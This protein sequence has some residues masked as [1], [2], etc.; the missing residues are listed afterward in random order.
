MS[1]TKKLLAGAMALTLG[2]SSFYLPTQLTEIIPTNNLISAS[3]ETS[4][5]YEYELLDDGTVEIT[6]YNGED[7]NVTIPSAIAGKKVTSIG[8]GAFYECTSLTSVTIPNSVTSI[9]NWV[10]SGCSSLKSITIPSSVT[11]IGEDSFGVCKSLKNITIDSN[12]NNYSSQDGVLFN[13]DKTRLIKYPG[14]NTRI[15]YN[16]P[17][18]VTVIRSS[19][20]SDCT[21]LKIITIPNSIKSIGDGAFSGCSSL[22]NV[23]IPNSVTSIGYGAFGYCSSL[24]SI[25]IPNSVT[26]IGDNAFLDCDFLEIINTDSNNGHYS[27]KDGVLFNKDKTKLIKYPGANTR[28]SYTIPNGVITISDY[29]FEDCD[30]LTSI[31]IP[32]SVID[33]NNDAFSSCDF[34]S[35][36]VDSDNKIYSSQNGILFNKNK[37]E[38]IKCLSRASEISIPNS[39][40]K[41]GNSAFESCYNLTDLFIYDNVKTIG[42]RAFSSCYNLTSVTI[43]NGVTNI[44]YSAFEYCSNLTDVSFGNSVTSIGS[45]VFF[46]CESLT[47][48]TIPKSVAYIGESAFGWCE[49]LKDIYYTGTEEDFNRIQISSNEDDLTGTNNDDLIN[50]TIHYNYKPVHTHSYTSK[51]T[52][53]PTCTSTGVRTYTCSC[54]D[55]YT[56]IIP[57]IEHDYTSAITKQPTCTEEGVKTY[58]CSCGDNYTETLPAT[59]HKYL[60]TVIKPTY[61]EQGYT[62]HKCSVCGSS[63]KDNYTA[64]LTLATVSNFKVTKTAYN[65]IKLGWNAVPNA[66]GYIIWR[67][68]FAKKQ[69]IKIN[70]NVK[71]NSFLFTHL[72]SGTKYRFSVRAFKKVNGKTVTSPS[73]PVVDGYTYLPTVSNFK[74]TATA[75]NAIKLGWNKVA[76]ANGYYIYRYDYAKKQWKLINNNVKS[77]TFLFTHLNSGSNYKFAVRAFKKID[78]K[79]IL[80]QSFPTVGSSTNPATVNFKVTA[81]SKK[82]TVKW[83]KVTGATGYKVYYKTSKNGSWKLIK[84]ANNKTTSYTKTGL[85]KGKTY[86]FTVK[87]YRTVGGKTYNGKFTT[88]SVKIK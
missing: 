83:S 56:E 60:T 86:Y 7:E 51:I 45:Y 55:S 53:Q 73:F 4:G 59:G 71:T 34:L 61:I 29:A 23:T 63:Y 20:F 79:N 46:A 74:V 13:K 43:G 66:D 44:G 41:I 31:I 25:T 15:S 80:S 64:K 68:D 12:N 9:R 2:L 58:T 75:N 37:T 40:E 11:S 21:N 87:A 84:T 18:G 85:L 28:T 16:I 39:V 78:G 8:D 17:S 19:A 48:I 26:S 14:G 52:K 82:S 54:G 47:N 24:T 6:G 67:Y 88:K 76:G 3:A 81:G 35:I 72:N 33:I 30:N 22:T 69:W 62:L 5:D 65:A 32:N 42:N 10:F 57:K 50:A 77:N 49:N 70:D 38:L 36:N 27:S 1:L